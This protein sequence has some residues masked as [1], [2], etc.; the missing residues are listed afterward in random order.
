MNA[1]IYDVKLRVLSIKWRQAFSV[2]GIN[3]PDVFSDAGTTESPLGIPGQR[4]IGCPRGDGGHR[5]FEGVSRCQPLLSGRGGWKWEWCAGSGGG[6]GGGG[7][8]GAAT[9]R[10][11]RQ[12]EAFGG[13]AHSGGTRASTPCC[14]CIGHFARPARRGELDGSYGVLGSRGLSVDARDEWVWPALSSCVGVCLCFGVCA[15]ADGC[16]S[17][18]V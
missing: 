1:I 14:S 12:C 2:I 15:R 7:A 10:S 4:R 17:A 18:S 5:H 3:I 16:P 13:V 11:V 8:G 9:P 6:R